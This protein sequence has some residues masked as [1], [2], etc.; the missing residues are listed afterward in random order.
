[1]TRLN[2]LALLALPALA[3]TGCATYGELPTDRVASAELRFANGLPAGTAQL[4]RAGGELRIS[5]A[6]AGLEAGPHGFHLHTTGRC[7]APDFT[8]AG[9]HLNPTGA[10]HGSENPQG[11]HLGDLPNL[12]IAGNGTGSTTATISDDPAMAEAAIFDADGTAVMIH[13]GADDYM[14]DP[15]GAAGSRVACGVLTRS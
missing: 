9:G 14:S 6:F 4:Y 8:S 10:E 3:L 7:D 13:A 15:A 11:S 5:G 1:M 12:Q 2:R